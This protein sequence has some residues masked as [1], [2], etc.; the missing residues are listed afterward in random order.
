MPSKNNAVTFT[1]IADAV[2]GH[3]QVWKSTLRPNISY[4]AVNFIRI[5]VGKGYRDKARGI[6]RYEV[7]KI[8]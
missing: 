1:P 3:C 5:I 8:I 7:T 2:F 4:S 6:P